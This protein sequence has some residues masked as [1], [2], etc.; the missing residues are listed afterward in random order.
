M[1]WS[2]L[3]RYAESLYHY[4][5]I[6]GHL[7]NFNFFIFRIFPITFVGDELYDD[8]QSEFECDTM[9]PGCKL[10]CFN[11]FNPIDNYRLWA[12]HLLFASIPMLIYMMYVGKTT[13]RLRKEEDVDI[14]NEWGVAPDA[15]IQSLSRIDEEPDSNVL[16]YSHYFCS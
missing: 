2:L 13:R 3:E 10:V 15:S 1:T 16:F 7:W 9:Q 14:V 4:Q 5:T 12:I 6:F 11:S 8:E